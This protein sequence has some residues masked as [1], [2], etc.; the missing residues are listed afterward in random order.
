MAAPNADAVAT[1]HLTAGSIG[2]GIWPYSALRPK[3]ES[4]GIGMG[5]GTGV[6]GTRERDRSSRRQWLAVAALSVGIA[7]TAIAVPP[8]IAAWSNGGTPSSGATPRVPT[9]AAQAPSTGSSPGGRGA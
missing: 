9:G 7:A 6:T 4:V 1:P 2:N 8:L 5:S 3:E